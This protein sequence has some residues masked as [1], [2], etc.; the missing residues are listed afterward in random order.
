M[1]TE[2]VPEEDGPPSVAALSG[3]LE[4]EGQSGEGDEPKQ[5]RARQLVAMAREKERKAAE[6]KELQ[7]AAAEVLTVALDKCLTEGGWK[8]KT[9]VFLEAKEEKVV[10]NGKSSS[11]TSAPAA[12]TVEATHPAGAP[13]GNRF[14]EQKAEDRKSKQKQAWKAA[15]RRRSPRAKPSAQT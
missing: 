13:L 12:S 3:S 7:E 8:A 5:K 10:G 15:R 14:Q 11:A 4:R 1:P 2:L 6:L 9:S